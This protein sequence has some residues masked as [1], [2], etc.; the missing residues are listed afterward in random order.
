METDRLDIL[1]DLVYLNTVLI[2][3]LL[4]VNDMAG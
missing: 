2:L 1:Y 3:G 4:L